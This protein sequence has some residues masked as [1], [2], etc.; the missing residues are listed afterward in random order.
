MVD[1]FE[2]QIKRPRNILP[3]DGTADYYG[4]I[5]SVGDADHFLKVLLM[6]VAWQHDEV[7][8]FGKKITTKRKA[9]W[10]GDASFSYT[11]SGMTKTA[12]PWTKT[13]LTIKETLEDVCGERY[14][15]CLLNLYHNG[16]EGMGWHNDGEK[17]LK[18]NGAIASFSLGAERV[19]A[20]QHKDTKEKV[21]LVLAH[22]SLLVMK[23]VTQCHWLHRLPLSKRIH[24]PRVN[25]TFRTIVPSVKVK[26]CA[27]SLM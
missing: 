6:D 24:S 27:R 25:L 26:G 13:L 23:G 20:F 7:L 2:Q 17:D 3:Y 18:K 9:A 19:F 15:A 12:L 22:G 14:N 16:S 8:I 11:Y 4:A 10:Y 5:M 21:S 1:L